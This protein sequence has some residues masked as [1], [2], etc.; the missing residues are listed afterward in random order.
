MLFG[1][2][3]FAWEALKATLDVIELVKLNG[4][5]KFSWDEHQNGIKLF[6]TKLCICSL[7]P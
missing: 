1:T 2:K 7:Y 5:S 6:L 4:S 3:R